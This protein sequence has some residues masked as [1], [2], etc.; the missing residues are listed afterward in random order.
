NENGHYDARVVQDTVM[1]VNPDGGDPHMVL[2]VVV[3]EGPKYAIA[4]IEWTGNTLYNDAVL[5]ERLG[6]M[7][8]DTYNSKTIE[9]NLYG[10]GKDNDVYSL[11]Q[12]SGHMRFNVEPRVT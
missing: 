6:L 5:T 9:E 11:Y 8:G 3:E 10:S 7:P 2:E 4:D 12:N 1:M